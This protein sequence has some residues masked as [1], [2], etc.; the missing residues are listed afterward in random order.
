MLQHSPRANPCIHVS[1]DTPFRSSEKVVAALTDKTVNQVIRAPLLSEETTKLK[2]RA[3]VQRRFHEKEKLE[4]ISDQLSKIK[5]RLLKCV[6][7]K[8][9]SNWITAMPFEE[10][11]YFLHKGDFRD[12]LCLRYS[13]RLNNLP[14]RCACGDS[15]S[16]NHALVC[17]KGGYTIFRHNAAHDLMETLLREVCPSTLAKPPLQPLSGEGL[18]LLTV[19]RN[20][21]TRLDIKAL[22]FWRVDKRHFLM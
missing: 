11:D 19:N 3:K 7:G 1:T 5:Q 16:V 15:M 18:E 21:E 8:G 17:H 14:A 13:W 12:A 6:Q 4:V 9:A 22:G 2:A 20:Q 10:Y